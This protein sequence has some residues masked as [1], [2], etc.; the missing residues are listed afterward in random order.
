MG[1][2]SDVKKLSED[3]ISSYDLR[4]KAIGELVSDTHNTLKGYQ[5]DRKKMT[6][7]LR[8]N[9]EEAKTE[10]LKAEADRLKTFR[11]IMEDT[12]KF[13]DDVKKFVSDMSE[14]TE[15]LMNQI[16]AEHKNRNKEVLELLEK[17][18]KERK[19]MSDELIGEIQARQDERNKEVLDLLHEFK[20]EREKM[21]AN[22]Q[23]LNAEM[24]KRR[25]IKPKLEAEA[26][27][28]SVKEAIEEVEK[29]VEEEV[30][31]EESL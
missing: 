18:E 27:V 12:K 4:V 6:S 7:D 20:T 10:R 31:A 22:W 1:I 17:S 21:A 25:G 29:V 2:A 5:D 14:E 11:S 28:M 3:V 26:R 24:A 9:L 8:K 15:N 30:P 19:I 23:A 13:L 16:R